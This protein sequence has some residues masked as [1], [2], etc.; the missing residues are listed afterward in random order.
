MLLTDR[1]T[2]RQ[3]D[4]QAYRQ[5][6]E[7]RQKDRQ[8]HKCRMVKQIAICLWIDTSID[9]KAMRD[10]PNYQTAFFHSLS[11]SIPFNLYVAI[12]ISFSHFH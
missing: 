9:A 7:Y 6:D 2:H 5:Y 10:E 1:Q 11:L 3:T 4:R 12:S 8:T